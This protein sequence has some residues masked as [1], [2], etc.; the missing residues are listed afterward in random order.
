MWSTPTYHTTPSG[1]WR[2]LWGDL[3]PDPSPAFS[4]SRLVRTR[5]THSQVVASLPCYGPANVDKQRGAGVFERSIQARGD[6]E[7]R[8]R[9]IEGSIA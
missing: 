6:A 7:G 2:K 1:I 8:S 4:A 9:V 5:T 3:K